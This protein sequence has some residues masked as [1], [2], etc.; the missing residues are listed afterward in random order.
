MNTKAIFEIG[1]IIHVRFA[2]INFTTLFRKKLTAQQLIKTVEYKEFKK[3]HPE[4][5]RL[6]EEL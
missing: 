3:S 6:A 5:C 4:L 2:G 1:S